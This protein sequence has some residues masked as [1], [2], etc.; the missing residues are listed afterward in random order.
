MTPVPASLLHLRDL[1]FAF[2][3]GLECDVRRQ[4]LG[5]LPGE[6]ETV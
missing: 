3:L 1:A 5:R 6:A 4:G 2:E